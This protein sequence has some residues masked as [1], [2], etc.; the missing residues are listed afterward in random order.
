MK[1]SIFTL[2]AVTLL[3]A[4]TGCTLFS[5]RT[6]EIVWAKMGTPARIV[7]SEPVKVL[8]PQGDGKWTPVEADLSGMMAI[9]E[10][11]LEYLKSLDK[12]K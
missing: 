9:D 3:L 8:V 12:G 10:P 11:T 1:R 6:H 5:E 2:L 7:G 4:P